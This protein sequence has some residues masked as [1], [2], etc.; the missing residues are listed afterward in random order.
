M[1]GERIR[2]AMIGCGD[3]SEFHAPALAQAGFELTAVASRRGSKRVA[4]FGARHGFAAVYSDVDALFDDRTGWDAL[5]ITTPTEATARLTERGVEAGK[6]ILAEKP[7]A[8]TPTA[9]DNLIGVGARVIVGYNRR[10]YGT[11]S[12]ARCFVGQGDPVLATLVLP[13]NVTPDP[14]MP[15][16]A[17]LE[18][19]F[20]NSVHGL[21][22]ARWVLGD[23]ELTHV[24]RM[25][26]ATGRLGGF[27][28]DLVT[29]RGDL[30]HVLGNWGAPT[31][32]A[33]TLDRPGV[34]CEL[35]PFEA[36]TFYEGMDL[37]EPTP[38]RPIRTYTPRVSQTVRLD[39]IDTRFKPG[40]VRQAEAF[41]RLCTGDDPS[42]AATLT[43]AR[44]VLAIAE[45]IVGAPLFVG[46]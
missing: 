8:F 31:N 1:T 5:V 38:E 41:A 21:D 20:L 32:F 40:F 11:V 17:Y 39:E 30:L 35:R 3:I 18:P 13:D 34:R 14:T 7:V 22:V 16:N 19:F 26:D 44:A 2:V 23:L 12:A 24:D 29:P 27:S 45:A 4:D 37:L 42:P 33:L 36:T 10:F 46:G 15:G 6:P 9:L 28:A 25:V 43:D